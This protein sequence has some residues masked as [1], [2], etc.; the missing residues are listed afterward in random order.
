[1]YKPKY[2]EF[3]LIAEHSTLF[4]IFGCLAATWEEL[5]QS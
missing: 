2:N 4:L 3:M 5:S 1:M